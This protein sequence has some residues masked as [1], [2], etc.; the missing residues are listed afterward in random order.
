[1]L[2]RMANGTESSYW[3]STRAVEILTERSAVTCP[4]FARKE[5]NQ[6]N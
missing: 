6:Q 4:D 2:G 3:G 1:M 5:E